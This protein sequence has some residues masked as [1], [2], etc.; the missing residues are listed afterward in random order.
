M[1]L[2][3]KIGVCISVM[4]LSGAAA[5]FGAAKGDLLRLGD[6]ASEQAHQFRAGDSVVTQTLLAEVGKLRRSHVARVVSGRG[7]TLGFEMD[8]SGGSLGDEVL[9]EIEEIHDR[10]KEVFGYTVLVNDEE[11]YFRTYEEMGA[12]P[13][14]YFVRVPLKRADGGHLRVTFR[15]ESEAS[16]AIGRVWAYA[17]FFALAEREGTY[18]KMTFCD[19]PDVLLGEPKYDATAFPGVSAENY[20]RSLWKKLKARFED[21]PYVPGS[22]S[23]VLYAFRPPRDNREKIDAE[24]SRAAAWNVPSQMGFLGTEWGAHPYGMDGL[25]GWFGDGK[26]S[27]IRFDPS[28]RTFHP[29]WPDTPGGVT[30]PTWNDPQLNRYLDHRLARVARYYADRRDFLKARGH[31]PPTPLICQEWGL[32][33]PGLG[34]WNDAAVDAARRDGVSLTPTN[35][36]SHAQKLWGFMNLASVPSRFA[37]AFRA[38]AGRDSVV[39]DRGVVRLPDD[40]L[41]DQYFFHTF[42]PAVQPLYD[43]QWAGWQTGVGL[44]VW[45]TGETGPHVPHAY[46]DYVIALGKLVTVNLERGFFRPKN[47][48]FVH[49][50][51]ELGFQWVTPCNSLPGDADLFLRPAREI[52]RRP[53]APALHFDRKI[54]DVRFQ[55]DEAVGPGDMVLAAENVTLMGNPKQPFRHLQIEDGRNPGR[56]RYRLTN[57]GKPFEGRLELSLTGGILGGEENRIDVALGRDEQSL[58][59]VGSLLAKD[60][61]AEDHWPWTRRAKLDMGEGLKGATDGCVELVFRVQN[62]NTARNVKLDELSVTMPW[63]RPSG[64]GRLKPLLVKQNRTFRLWV[65]DRAVFERM[66]DDYRQTVGADESLRQAE[67]AADGG[68]YHAAYRLLAGAEA[69][70]LPA[71]FAVRGHGKLGRYPLVITLASDERVVLVEL[72][73]A[74]REEFEWVMKTEEPQ[75]CRLRVEGL[76]DGARYE[77]QEGADNRYR[78]GVAQGANAGVTVQRGGAEFVFTLKPDDPE[79]HS[80]PRRLEGIQAGGAPGGI[81]VETQEPGL[82]MDN[83]IFVPVATNA[84]WTRV[85]DGVKEEGKRGRSLMDKVELAIDESGTAR[86]VKVSYGLDRGRI[87]GFQPPVF[88]GAPHNG[89]IELENGRRYELGNR[90]PVYTKFEVPGLLPHYRNNRDGDFAKALKPGLEVE[91]AYCPYTYNGRLPRAIEVSVPGYT[92]PPAPPRKR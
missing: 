63:D 14:H 30:W 12:G 60:F 23:A 6:P 17:D 10:R 22:R 61:V 33:C 40:R 83:P 44:K 1:N 67:A 5:T 77:L 52:D 50:L 16:F 78:V 59:P 92:N 38:A 46:Y 90:L 66:L 88:K 68:R 79:A 36:P 76:R 3:A 27:S 31:Q 89:I 56:V 71:R 75:T 37:E 24:L 74:G 28:T 26:Y 84:V 69:Q 65:Q 15:N 51:Y 13:N 91:I 62:K 21:S 2:S 82:W 57:A 70:A 43:D 19:E 32:S 20:A 39:V 7:T 11:A 47:L 9:L 58:R 64:Q 29:S 41:C 8:V 54:L 73:K 53:A 25:G 72:V 45:T 87:K 4:A 42:Y 85:P 81:W 34:D 55:R 86:E 49:T 35:R 80:L 48:D 18:R